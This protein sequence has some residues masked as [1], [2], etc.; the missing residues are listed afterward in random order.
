M[1]RGTS[2]VVQGEVAPLAISIA[3]AVDDRAAT[4]SNF[5]AREDMPTT[6]KAVAIRLQNKVGRRLFN[7]IA[8]NYP[9]DHVGFLWEKSP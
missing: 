3:V 6:T 5:S 7:F 2:Q 9:V 4:G 1:E 8:L